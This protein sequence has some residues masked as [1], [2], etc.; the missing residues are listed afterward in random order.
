MA[1]DLKTLIPQIHGLKLTGIWC[2]TQMYDY[3]YRTYESSTLE[4]SLAEY[5]HEMDDLTKVHTLK[6]QRSCKILKAEM[7]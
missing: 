1:S 4:P 7:T 6:I 2:I 3:L 5:P